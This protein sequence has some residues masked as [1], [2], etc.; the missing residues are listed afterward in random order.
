MQLQHEIAIEN[1]G[2]STSIATMLEE[3]RASKIEVARKNNRK[4]NRVIRIL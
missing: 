4:K 1:P 3:M 2:E